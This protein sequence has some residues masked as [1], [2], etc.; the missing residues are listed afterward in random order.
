MSEEIPNKDQLAGDEETNSSGNK[1]DEEK[2]NLIESKVDANNDNL[3]ELSDPPSPIGRAS[4]LP[5]LSNTGVNNFNSSLA[6]ARAFSTSSADNFRVQKEEI[7]QMK[8]EAKRELYKCGN[9]FKKLDDIPSWTEYKKENGYWLSKSKI[10]EKE[11]SEIF[12][13]NIFEPDNEINS[14]VSIIKA[15]ITRLEID[16]IVN[17]ANNSLLGGGGV[18]GAI[19][20]AAGRMLY[21]E[22]TT[23]NGC[24]TGDA[25]ITGG[26]NLPARYVIHTVGPIGEN[27]SKLKSCYNSSLKIAL[28]NNIRSIA[29]PCI[30]TGVYGY[31]NREAS[32]VA[33]KTIREFLEAHKSSIDRIIFVLFMDI[34]IQFYHKFMPYIF[35]E[36]I[37]NKGNLLCYILKN[38]LFKY[39]CLILFTVAY[40]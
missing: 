7:L 12:S 1:T 36:E 9:D 34:D 2:L 30:S 27:P 18:D 38:Y 31:P 24:D 40:Y 13:N 39:L 4:T 16:G 8:I 25:K 5:F 19:H 21:N 10:S 33:M 17:A 22:C 29:F 28:E 14:K 3:D 15:D 11:V 20:R 37:D 35:P 26:Y 6:G 32:A 23:L